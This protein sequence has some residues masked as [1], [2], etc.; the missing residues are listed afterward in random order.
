MSTK[1]L[2]EQLIVDIAKY[3]MHPQCSRLI[4]FVYDPEGRVNNPR[5]MENDLSN[6]DSDIDVR[7]MIVP[8]QL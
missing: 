3:K 8:K 5:G 4:C 6:C 2:G 7:T 1:D